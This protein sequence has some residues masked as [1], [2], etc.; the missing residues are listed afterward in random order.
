MKRPIEHYDEKYRQ[1]DSTEVETV[2]ILSHPR[3]RFEMAVR[4]LSKNACGKYL[5]IG[6]GSGSVALTVLQKYDELVLT[7]LSSVRVKALSELFRGNPRVKTIHHDIENDKLDFPDGYF[8]SVAM[9]AVIEHLFDPIAVLK[10][11]SH[12]IKPG[13]RLILDTPNV[14][15]WTRRVKLLMGFFPS[16]ASLDEGLICYDR[17]NPTKLYDEG[18]LHYFSFRSLSRVCKE[19]A[20][21]RRVEWHG[22][23]S[24]KTSRM[25]PF[26]SRSLPT[27]FSEV[28][29][30]A[31]K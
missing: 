28:F 12:V 4:A 15:K 25:P 22:Y 16:T 17:I 31:Y 7:E 20:G 24:W 26:F 30:V 10:E 2:P 9:I 21:F 14:A 3:D 11:L 23:G 19:R 1:S 27:L 5:E 18:H 8:D 6:A 13:G 29:I